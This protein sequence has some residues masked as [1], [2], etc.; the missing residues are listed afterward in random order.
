MKETESRKVQEMEGTNV[1]VNI[2]SPKRWTLLET[3]SGVKQQ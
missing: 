2:A 3:V 1:S